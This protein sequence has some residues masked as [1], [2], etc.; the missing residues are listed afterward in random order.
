MSAAPSGSRMNPVEA[1]AARPCRLTASV[2]AA[3][4]AEVKRLAAAENL[5][6]S[7]WLRRAIL[8][9]AFFAPDLRI[10]LAEVTGTRQL[11]LGII[12]ALMAGPEA[13]EAERTRIAKILRS[14]A[15][16]ADV[17]KFP[18]ADA[19]IKAAREQGL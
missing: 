8:Q 5:T 16:A 14:E 6:V 19:R 9:A 2:T 1:A 3:E 4:D 17:R 11:L 18:L 15:I 13:S 7:Q 10:V 12:A